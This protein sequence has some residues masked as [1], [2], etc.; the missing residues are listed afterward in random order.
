MVCVPCWQ[1]L[2][3]WE[4]MLT[5]LRATL[6][7]F[8]QGLECAADMHAE[9][10]LFGHSSRKIPAYGILRR[11]LSCSRLYTALQLGKTE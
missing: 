9:D 10:T 8:S 6:T 1:H 5:S 2:R 4:Q 11:G 3:L 7:C